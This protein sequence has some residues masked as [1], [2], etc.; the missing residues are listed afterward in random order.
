MDWT[1]EIP[2]LREE[3]EYLQEEMRM[4]RDEQQLNDD[5][6]EISNIRGELEWLL[7]EVETIKQESVEPELGEIEKIKQAQTRNSALHSDIKAWLEETT[8]KEKECN[9]TKITE[10]ECDLKAQKEAVEKM[11]KM[12]QETPNNDAGNMQ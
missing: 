8:N 6:A 11:L 10:L 5:A 3:I 1:A 4:V 2:K 9:I 12:I 7:E